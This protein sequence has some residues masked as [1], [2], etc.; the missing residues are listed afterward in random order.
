MQRTLLSAATCSVIL[1]GMAGALAQEFA[2]PT[3][4]SGIAENLCA[5]CHRVQKGAKGGSKIKEPAFQ[6]IASRRATT[7]MSLRVFLR[8]P[9]RNMPNLILSENDTADVIA[10]I[11]SLK[12]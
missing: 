9:H 6:E 5:N 8:T 10:Y 12:K 4:G 7:E 2:N 3:R 11:L 1:F